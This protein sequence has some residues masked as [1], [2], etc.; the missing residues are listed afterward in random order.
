MWTYEQLCSTNSRSITL[1]D[2]F[3]ELVRCVM[4]LSSNMVE[5]VASDKQ[6]AAK[7]CQNDHSSSGGPVKRH[8]SARIRFIDVAFSIHLAWSKYI[9]RPGKRVAS[10]T[11]SLDVRHCVLADSVLS[12]AYCLYTDITAS[13]RH[14]RQR[15][16]HQLT[17][18]FS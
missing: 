16:S 2:S 17:T 14:A 9:R 7:V 3:L 6:T 15:I 10:S 4:E 5:I 8:Q 13:G 11:M 1:S 18:L 12:N